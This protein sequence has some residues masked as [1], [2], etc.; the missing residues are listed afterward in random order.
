MFMNRLILGLGV[1]AASASVFGTASCSGGAAGNPANS[2]AF[3]VTQIST[4]QGQ[5]YPYR[6]QELDAF[7]NPSQNILNIESDAALQS[8][9]SSTNPVLPVATFPTTATLPGGGAGNQ[10]VLVRFSHLLDPMSILSNTAAD[11]ATNSGLTTAISL[12]FQDQATETSATLTGQA[13]VAGKTFFGAGQPLVDAVG[14]DDNGNVTILDPR[15]N[16]F[17]MGFSGDEDLVA[18]NSFVFVADDDNDLTMFDTFDEAQTSDADAGLIRI[19]VSNA[20]LDSDGD[21]LE[22]E[23]CTATTVGPDTQAPQVLGFSSGT[24]EVSPGNG[25]LAVDPTSTI[26]VR[27]SKP[28]QPSDIGQFFTP[29]DLTP[30]S[31]AV[32]LGVT[33]GAVSFNVIYYAD[34]AGFGDLCNYVLTPAYTL[35]GL[36]TV[37]VTLDQQNITGLNGTNLGTGVVTSFVTDEGP[38]LVNA[39]VGADAIYVG[40]G[41]DEPGVAVIDLNGFGQGTGD[42]TTSRFPANPNVGTGGLIPPL[43]PSSSSVDAGGAG[44]FTFTE[45]SRGNTLLLQAPTIGEVGD[46]HMGAPL[47]LV[48]NNFNI[49]PNAS[50]ANQVNPTS[51]APQRGNSIAQIP[52][53]NPPRLDFPPPNVDQAIFAQEPTAGP[54][55]CVATSPRNGLTAGNPFAT[56][57]SQVG[58]FRHTFDGGPFVGPGPQPPSP[59][60]P[61]PVCPYTYRQQIGHFLYVLDRQNSQV[62]VVNS[63]RFTVLDTISVPDPFAAALSPSLAQLAVTSFSGSNVTIIDTNPN[64]STFNTIVRAVPVPAGPTA[65]AYQPDNEALVVVSTS[66]NT[67]TI[68]DTLDLSVVAQPSG[69]LLSPFDVVVSERQFTSAFGNQVWLAYI[70]NAN[71]TIAAFESGPDGAN[72]IG[73]NDIITLID[74]T[75]TRARVLRTD[76]STLRDSFFVGHTDEFG[77]GVVSRVELIS[78]FGGAAPTNQNIGNGIQL[79]PTFRQRAWGVTTV[80]G[81]GNASN[82]TAPRLSGNTVTDIATDCMVNFGAGVSQP[83]PLGA[84]RS[85]VGGSFLGHSAKGRILI[86]PAGPVP[87]T[88]AQFMFVALADRGF[89]DIIDLS[90][91]AIVRSLA[92]PNVTTLTS[93]WR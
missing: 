90:N 1:A 75:F 93:Y 67:V 18:P 37:T 9:H 2:G 61:P 64:S 82:P 53:P 57:P 35:P 52:H 7:G 39:P 88:S 63:N 14:L 85:P 91:G 42:P 60:P 45:D 78:S 24:V 22:E 55:P 6:I 51:G 19:A 4:G 36:S 50:A 25:D 56:N 87:A 30:S 62:V 49:N 73:F 69:N 47:D 34:P 27:F 12:I 8:N 17:P 72:G 59:A 92:Q 77:Q 41:G 15:A 65:V 44:A 3:V 11:Q 21:I 70:L 20:V 13:F 31:G 89:I 84:N 29:N 83:N 76:W 48:F 43:A 80:F 38:G 28:V 33:I 32:S 23:A 54:S 46:I 26:L 86:G 79:P 66:A 74:P 5:V 58:L 10:F 68:L 40:V 81:S 16:G 71:G